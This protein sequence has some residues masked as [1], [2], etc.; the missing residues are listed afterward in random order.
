[1]DCKHFICKI[2]CA[3]SANFIHCRGKKYALSTCVQN[4]SVNRILDQKAAFFAFNYSMKLI[5]WY[6]QV[7]SINNHHKNCFVEPPSSYNTQKLLGLHGFL[8]PSWM[9]V[10]VNGNGKVIFF[11]QNWL[12]P[13]T[14]QNYFFI[15]IPIQQLSTYM[16][17]KIKVTTNP[18]FSEILQNKWLD[19]TDSAGC[20]MYVWMEKSFFMPESHLT[21]LPKKI[22]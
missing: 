10:T 12:K 14:L 2:L 13:T 3:M 6:L 16:C 15:H 9:D 22:G 17:Y 5:F 21:K 1:M 8:F 4:L 11:F 20:D 7:Y 19:V 18:L